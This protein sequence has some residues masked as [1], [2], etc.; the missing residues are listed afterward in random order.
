MHWNP[1]SLLRLLTQDV[2][3][4]THTL[5]TDALAKITGRHLVQDINP[6]LERS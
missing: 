3:G 5:C 4:I 1:P 6:G 2:F